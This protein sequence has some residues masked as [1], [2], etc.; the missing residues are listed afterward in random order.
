MFDDREFP[1]H[2][3]MYVPVLGRSL[4]SISMFDDLCYYTRFVHEVLKVSHGEMIIAKGSKIYDLYIL[5]GS[6]FVVHSSSASE[7]FHEKISYLI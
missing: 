5:E 7:E 1:L 4:L 2:N 3:V 6:N